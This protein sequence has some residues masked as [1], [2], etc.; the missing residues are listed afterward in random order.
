MRV[1]RKY[2]FYALAF[3]SA[4]TVAGI[5]AID[6]TISTLFIKDPWV[7]SFSCFLVGTLIS[8]IIILVF[9][10]PINKKE[11]IGAKIIDPSFRKVRLLKKEEIKYHLLAGLGN[12]ILTIGYLTLLSILGDPSSVLP[13]SQIVILYLILVES[14][15]LKIL[16]SRKR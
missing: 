11:T 15:H 13:F 2:L 7:F 5:S 14:S 8:L 1:R 12:S 16:Q 10:I 9:S 4:I 6:A 3:A